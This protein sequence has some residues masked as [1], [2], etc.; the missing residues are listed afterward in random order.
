M[1]PSGSGVES[2]RAARGRRESGTSRLGR[3]FLER[4]AWPVVPCSLFRTLALE[5][6]ERDGRR[7]HI[8][9]HMA[10]SC[11][12]VPAASASLPRS[13]NLVLGKSRPLRHRI[14]RQIDRPAKL[15]CLKRPFLLLAAREVKSMKAADT[16]RFSNMMLRRRVLPLRKIWQTRTTPHSC[17]Q[18]GG[19]IVIA[20][21]RPLQGQAVDGV[22]SRSVLAIIRRPSH[23]HTHRLT[24]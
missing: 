16:L 4:S 23:H 21:R 9:R 13:P 18:A 20:E 8:A 3:V 24:Q 6:M 2:A 5:H 10:L 11:R 14:G 12:P 22:A 19:M 7:I 15:W 17:G 1:Q